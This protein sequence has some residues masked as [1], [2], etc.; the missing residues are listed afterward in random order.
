MAKSV[1]QLSIAELQKI[2]K[3]RKKLAVKAPAL[4][5]EKAKLLKRLTAIDAELA[6]LGPRPGRRPGTKNAAPKKAR[7]G[8][9]PQKA[10]AAPASTAKLKAVSGKRLPRG[11]VQNAVLKV[12]AKGPMSPAAA[13]KAVNATEIEGVS[14]KAVA[15]AIA[16]MTKTG[17]V[18][19]TGRAMYKTVK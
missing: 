9:P 13:T 1:D 18:I 4:R 10:A 14:P 2:I 6:K 5:K 17:K 11:S 8:R 16:K 12:L 15:V 7:R 3:E 19:K